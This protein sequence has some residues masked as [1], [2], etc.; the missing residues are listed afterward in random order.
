MPVH[1]PLKHV[2]FVQ[3]VAFCQVPVVLHVCGCEELAHWVW[4]GPHTPWQLPPTHVVLAEHAEPLFPS[5][6][7]ELQISGC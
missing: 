3:A 1:E 7:V 6:P 5:V 4:P 2:W